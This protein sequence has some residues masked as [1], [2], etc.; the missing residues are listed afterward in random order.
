MM[1][2]SSICVAAIASVALTMG[3]NYTTHPALASLC[4]SSISCTLVFSE[5]NTGSGFGLGN[6]GTVDLELSGA[7][8]TITLDLADGFQL[9]NTGFP[10]SVG[11]VDSLGGGLSIGS[12]SSSLYS[13]A[14]S[15]ASKDLHFDGFGYATDTAA[16]SGPHPGSGVN[17]LSFTVSDPSL[18]DVNQLLNPFGGPAGQGPVYFVAD[19]YNS[20][21]A[22]TGAGNSG[23]IAVTG[24]SPVTI[25]EP[26]SLAVFGAALIML[27][28]A[29]RRNKRRSLA[30]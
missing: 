1:K 16:T 24:A 11:F 14:L 6:F 18:V 17:S 8:A 27:G 21:T 25:P 20:N 23:L 29:V 30:P 7:T 13:G 28:V 5:G 15:D 9:V 12:F 2:K 19:A 4:S 22:G 26:G 3:V 10:G